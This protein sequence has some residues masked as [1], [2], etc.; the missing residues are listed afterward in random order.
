MACDF[1]N[2]TGTKKIESACERSVNAR[3]AQTTLV[4]IV[5]EHEASLS[6]WQR[7]LLGLG[8]GRPRGIANTRCVLK[9][10]P[11]MQL[12]ERSEEGRLLLPIA[13][14]GVSVY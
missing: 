2:E 13:I 14:A 12:F 8:M 6:E 7:P 5:W 10:Q 4:M 1:V 9:N 11:C 3:G